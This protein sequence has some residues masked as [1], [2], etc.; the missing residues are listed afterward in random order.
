MA[1]GKFKAA[2]MLHHFAQKQHQ[3]RLSLR[4]AR[5]IPALVLHWVF[6]QNLEQL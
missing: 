6:L 4:A 1:T 5:F 2:L 3:S